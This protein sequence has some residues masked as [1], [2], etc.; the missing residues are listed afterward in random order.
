M[1]QA[2]GLRPMDRSFLQSR[3]RM[4][5]CRLGRGEGTDQCWRWPCSRPE[6]ARTAG[7]YLLTKLSDTRGQGGQSPIHSRQDGLRRPVCS[8][9]CE[10]VS[11]LTLRAAELP[12]RQV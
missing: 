10:L 11:G 5:T 9:A 1:A 8:H 3:E 12:G 4:E 2:D 6:A 7:I